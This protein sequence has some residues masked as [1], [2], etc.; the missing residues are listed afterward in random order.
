MNSILNLYNIV[1]R[2]KNSLLFILDIYGFMYLYF[3][4]GIY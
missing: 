3:F 2:E 1:V 4:S